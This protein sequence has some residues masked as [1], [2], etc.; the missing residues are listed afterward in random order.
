MTTRRFSKADLPSGAESRELHLAFIQQNLD[1][2]AAGAW[3]GRGH[4][5]LTHRNWGTLHLKP[6]PVLEVNQTFR[7]QDRQPST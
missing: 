6:L 2:A 7:C 5:G 4:D 1:I 3:Q